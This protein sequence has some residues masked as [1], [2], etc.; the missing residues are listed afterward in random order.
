MEYLD[1]GGIV[2]RQQNSRKG[3]NFVFVF[4]FVFG[5]S[6]AASEFEERSE[7]CVVSQSAATSNSRHQPAAAQVA[8]DVNIFHPVL[9][10]AANYQKIQFYPG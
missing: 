7:L 6:Y 2:M 5:G 9:S 4:V 8:Q 3:V 1:K 10:G